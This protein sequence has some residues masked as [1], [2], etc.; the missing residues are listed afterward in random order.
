[1]IIKDLRTYVINFLSGVYDTQEIMSFFY[2]LSDEIIGLSRAHI[3]IHLD[4]KVPNHQLETF[5]KALLRLKR[6]EPIQYIVGKTDFY[7]LSFMVNKNTLIPRPETEELV[8][9]ILK[10]THD[11]TSIDV[12]DIGT[13]TGCIAIALAKNLPNAKI[14]AIDISEK[15]IAIAQKNAQKHQVDVRFILEDILNTSVLFQE[16]DIIVSN[17]PYVRVQEK[18]EM[19]PNVLEYEPHNALFVPDE[20][21]L[22]F[23]EKIA[24]LA[25]RKLK[26]NGVLYLEINQ[27]LGSVTKKMIEK[28]GYSDVEIR[29][30]MSHN[31]RIIRAKL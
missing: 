13:G 23:Y 16:F 29:K 30:D 20:D 8:D 3:A 18:N 24:C 31:D 9:F 25:K 10:N 26:N 2:I 14:Y 21:P 15:A 17:P 27:Y 12:L 6:Y 4:Q 5:H 22:L 19:K 7:G 1:M 28:Q 11:Q